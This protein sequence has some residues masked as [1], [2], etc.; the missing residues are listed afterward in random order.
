VAQ[1]LG[2]KISLALKSANMQ[3]KELAE[4]L[5]IA[6]ATVSRY[7]SGERDPKPEVLAQIAVTLGTTTDYLLGLDTGEFYHPKVKRMLAR[8]AS[9]MTS[10]EKKA[11]FDALYGEE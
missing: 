8:N 3:Q 4:R 5:G 6:T 10:Q 11:L 9:N 1:K 7:I 2:E